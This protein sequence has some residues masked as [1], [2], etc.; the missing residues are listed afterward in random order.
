MRIVKKNLDLADVRH[1]AHHLRRAGIPTIAFFIV[2]FPGE[3]RANVRTTLEFAKQLALDYDTLLFVAT[4]LPGTP[5]EVECREK[6]YLLQAMN[7]ETLLSAIRLNQTPLIT[8]RDFTK[9]DLFSW[10]KE[11]LDTPELITIGEHMP[12]FFSSSARTG[13]SL[14]QLYGSADLNQLDM[15]VSYWRAPHNNP[16]SVLSGPAPT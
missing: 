1:A 7:N 3:S 11:V 14:R 2:G 5:L 4:P 6:G 10:T 9:Q 8:T 16:P 13:Q 12:F 15:P